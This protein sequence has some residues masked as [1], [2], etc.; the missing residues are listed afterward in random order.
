MIGGRPVV[1]VLEAVALGEAGQ[2]E[3]VASPAL[4]EMR[5]GQQPIDQLVV[6]VGRGIVHKRRDFFRRR[7]QADQIEIEPAD[8]LPLAG[9]R[10]GLHAGR[11]HPGENEAVERRAAP[12]GVFHGRQLDASQRLER[13]ELASFGAIVFSV[14]AL[15]DAGA[16]PAL[17]E[18]S[19]G[20]PASIQLAICSM[21]AAGSCGFS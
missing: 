9:R 15:A 5:P 20:V 8:Q 3:P 13:P 1:I 6:S 11:F 19:Y 14:H 10:I 16:G 4:A 12:G 17:S 2:I 18:F 7:R 21:A